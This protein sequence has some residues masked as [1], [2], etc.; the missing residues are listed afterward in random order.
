[1]IDSV[2]MS[3]RFPDM[4]TRSEVDLNISTRQKPTLRD[5]TT[6]MVWLTDRIMGT[7][8]IEELDYIKTSDSNTARH[9]QS[10]ATTE[11]PNLQ[12]NPPTDK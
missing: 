1:M 3:Q 5:L 6:M 4:V 12:N 11:E 9:Y 8:L 2:E 10:P 7:D